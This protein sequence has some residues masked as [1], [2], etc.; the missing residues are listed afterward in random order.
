VAPPA[1]AEGGIG[2]DRKDAVGQVPVDK[3]LNMK[4]PYYKLGDLT[5]QVLADNFGKGNPPPP[6][7]PPPPDFTELKVKANDMQRTALA[8][9]HVIDDR[10]EQRWN[11]RVLEI[12][13]KRIA[14]EVIEKRVKAKKEQAKR[15]AYSTKQKLDAYSA[16]K[17]S[18][19]DAAIASLE[20]GHMSVVKERESKASVA[21]GI[22]IKKS[23]GAAEGKG[24]AALAD[25]NIF[26]A[27]VGKLRVAKA[28]VDHELVGL[29]AAQ[30]HVGAVNLLHQTLEDAVAHPSP[31][32]ELEVKRQMK[33]SSWAFEKSQKKEIKA[34]NKNAFEKTAEEHTEKEQHITEQGQKRWAKKMQTILDQ[35]TEDRILARERK[36]QEDAILKKKMDKDDEV[37]EKWTSHERK[38]TQEVMMK[39]EKATTLMRTS[40]I[41][42]KGQKSA[43]LKTLDHR[44][45]KAE[46]KMLKVMEGRNKVIVKNAEAIRV[47]EDTEQEIARHA[48]S[49]EGEEVLAELWESVA[50]EDSDQDGYGRA[51][52]RGLLGRGGR[53]RRA[54]VD[55]RRRRTYVPPDPRTAVAQAQTRELNAKNQAM[56]AKESTG[57][58]EKMKE[59][60]TKEGK[61]KR[62]AAA[63]EGS[64]KIAHKGEQTQ[65]RSKLRKAKR[66]RDGARRD[67]KE[68]N[69]KAA[70]ADT[71][72][73]RCK[74]H[75]ARRRRTCACDDFANVNKKPRRELGETGPMPTP[76]PPPPPPPNWTPARIPGKVCPCCPKSSP[77]TSVTCQLYHANEGN[78]KLRAGNEQKH[79]LA[80]ARK[81][82]LPPSE[83]SKWRGE[84]IN[85]K[86]GNMQMNMAGGGPML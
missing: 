43:F 16:S 8:K 9:K 40:E 70:D 3:K 35:D 19:R 14:D 28:H 24:D 48:A 50:D 25:R 41:T 80:L 27:A 30:R 57:K 79:K 31:Y 29:T 11:D 10:K 12:K 46:S 17:Q 32:A 54:P 39:A 33:E 68:A 67:V 34:K 45:K 64:R 74:S 23:Q 22:V 21:L 78:A 62:E 51:S 18:E 83:M 77:Y 49:P 75:I 86:T 69:E 38:G 65:L 60:K 72:N 4:N 55:V 42:A 85:A 47:V 73:R 6:R 61:S 58:A 71:Q 56:V 37:R 15:L 66:T 82:N 84:G 59:I 81:R 26:Q 1:P 52:G 36:A 63:A 5:K 13:S 2:K 7:G 76:P 44:C 53:R 20:S